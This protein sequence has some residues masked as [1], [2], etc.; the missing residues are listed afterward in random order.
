[1]SNALVRSTKVTNTPLFCS[2][3]FSEISLS[4]NTMPLVPRLVLNP[5]WPSGTYSSA[6]VDTSLF[7]NTLATILP[8]I[9]RRDIPLKLEQSDCSPL[10]LSRVMMAASRRSCGSFLCSQ[11]QTKNLWNLLVGAGP[12]FF[13]TSGGMPS[14]H[15]AVV[16]GVITQ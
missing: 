7:N 1:M 14:I 3:H 13:Q 4:A 2:R 16:V 9:A 12:P 8:A 15:A 6:I 11:Q 5:H 10:F